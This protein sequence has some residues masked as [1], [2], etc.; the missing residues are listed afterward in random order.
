MHTLPVEF[1]GKE[2]ECSMEEN[3][4]EMR[5]QLVPLC[6]KF[7]VDYTLRDDLIN[8]FEKQFYLKLYKNTFIPAI[9]FPRKG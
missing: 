4:T 9:S 3:F 7:P 2:V 6:A 8:P 5:F 1:P